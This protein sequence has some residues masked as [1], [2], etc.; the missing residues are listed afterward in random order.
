MGPSERQ[1][2]KG[3]FRPYANL[4]TK[5]WSPT[6]RVGIIE[7]EGILKASIMLERMMK[8]RSNAVPRETKFSQS[9]FLRFS[10]GGVCSV[11]VL[12]LSKLAM[13]VYL[14]IVCSL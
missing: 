5:I 10:V 14:M 11:I 3:N 1:S 2:E 8:T 13:N 7:P 4:F 9:H 12:D 6:K